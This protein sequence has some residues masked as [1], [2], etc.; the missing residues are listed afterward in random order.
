MFAGWDAEDVEFGYRLEKC[1][2]IKYLNGGVCIPFFAS[3]RLVCYY[4]KQQE[5]LISVFLS[6][7]DK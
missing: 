5:K 6:T 3:K 2:E 4:A 1:G 7:T